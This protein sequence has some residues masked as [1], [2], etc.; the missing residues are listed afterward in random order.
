M[1]VLTHVLALLAASVLAIPT[2]SSPLASSGAARL[3]LDDEAVERV[4]GLERV[5]HRPERHAGNPILTGTE[6]WE[7]WMIELNGRPIVHDAR[8]RQLRMYYGAHLSNP[9]APEGIRYKVCLALSEDGVHWRRPNLGLVEWEGSR[10]NNILPWGE[11]W[12]RRPNVILDEHDPDPARRYKM[13]FVDVIGGRTALTKGYSADGTHWRLNGDGKPWFRAAHNSNLLGWDASIGRYVL[14]PRMDGAGGVGR[15]T[16]ADFVTWTEP[17]PVLQPGPSDPGREFKGLAA[18]LYEDLYLGWLWVFDRNQ[19][20]EAELVSSRDGKA[21]RRATPGRSYFPR[22]VPGEWDSEMI[23]VVAPVVRDD[24][25]WIYYSGWNT[26][27]TADAQEKV[28]RGWVENGRRYQWAIGLATLRLD[29]FVSLDAGNSTGTLLT[30]PFELDGG[31]LAVNARVSGE[32]RVEVLAGDRPL[33]GYAMGDCLPLRGDGVRQPVRWK[34]HAGL[35]GLRGRTVQLR[36]TMRNGSLY[37]F[38]C[39]R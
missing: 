33:P 5:Y 8:A 12:M 3:F 31:T 39:G 23:L 25:I 27:Y 36:F 21:W 16:S 15:S 34:E 38:R 26:P 24:K 30:R 11:S 17:E 13:T 20:A 19:T 29:G 35:D 22:G 32:L 1:K 2:R 28:V 9:A 6:P 10:A 37:A 18:F 14:Y 7:K 4:D